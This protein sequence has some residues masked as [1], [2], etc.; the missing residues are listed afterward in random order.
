MIF[1]EIKALGIEET[2]MNVIKSKLED[3]YDDYV[4]RVDCLD[5]VE[6]EKE[7]AV[8]QKIEMLLKQVKEEL[9]K[10][11]DSLSAVIEKEETI[12]SSGMIPVDVNEKQSELKEAELEKRAD[13]VRKKAE[14]R[15]KEA[16]AE[17][18][19]KVKEK[20]TSDNNDDNTN[21][22]VVSTSLEAMIDQ[23]FVEYKNG[24][25]DKTYTL[26]KQ[27]VANSKCAGKIEKTKRSS[28]EYLLSRLYGLG[29]SVQK[30]EDVEKFWLESSAKHKNPLA[31]ME[32]AL[33]VS[34]LVP[35]SKT[36]QYD[37]MDK[38]LDYLKKAVDYSKGA[39]EYQRTSA[40]AKD[41]Y[42][43]ICIAGNFTRAQRRTALK[44][45]NDQI[46]AEDDLYIQTIK[47]DLK[48]GI[49]KRPLRE[50]VKKKPRKK[51]FAGDTLLKEN[52]LAV[53]GT[54]MFWYG[55]VNLFELL[56]HWDIEGYLDPFALRS[57]FNFVFSDM[58]IGHLSVQLQHI[59][60]LS[61]IFGGIVL[62]GFS[63]GA[64]QEGLEG[65]FI[66]VPILLMLDFFIVHDVLRFTL[67][68]IASD[69]WQ[70]IMPASIWKSYAVAS[71]MFIVVYLISNEMGKKMS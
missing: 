47:R 45:L 24:D 71:V 61:L 15:Q 20:L 18:Q 21:L 5:G 43:N 50:Y 23:A 52:V 7:E 3:L 2:D 19:K 51:H 11:N 46:E 32:L 16:E 40:D 30:D 37:N 33:K 38:A 59:T 67:N 39:P 12:R 49:G 62:R 1:D 25:F 28:G 26:L 68:H 14:N 29:H 65:R 48:A 42:I 22:G 69:I 41:K 64:H 55:L 54:F 8:L 34:N 53:I 31:C 63:D 17:T 10:K 58:V 35:K 57:A 9:E 56:C 27:T 70:Y 36:E 4:E 44:Y 6:R 60:I 66:S 13:E